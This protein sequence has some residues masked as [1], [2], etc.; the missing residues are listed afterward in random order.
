MTEL[1]LVEGP[2]GT[3]RKSRAALRPVPI[4]KPLRA[5]LLRH[6]LEQGRPSTGLLITGARGGRVSFEALQTRA[7]A[8]WPAGERFTAHELRHTFA[9]WLDAAGVRGT[10]RSML[11]G[12]STGPR[13]G[14]AAVT[15]R[16]THALPGDLELAREQLDAY[17]AREISVPTSVPTRPQQEERPMSYSDL[18]RIVTFRPLNGRIESAGRATSPLR[19]RWGDTVEILARELR[20]IGAQ[21]TVLEVDLAERDFR[22]DGLPRADRRAYTPGIRISFTAGRVPGKPSLRYEVGRFDDW[23]DNVRAVALALEALRKVDRYGVTKRG[24]QY[25]GWAL[26]MG[27]GDPS[28][29]RGRELIR[30][31]GGVKAALK[32]THPDHGGD[33]DAFAD[34]QAAR[35]DGAA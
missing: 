31:H 9:T 29:D 2:P 34:V 16:Y 24:E 15:A 6:L 28:P 33:A 20:A 5:L 26:P 1:L 14:S 23:Q 11:L 13:D 12:H 3:A 25:A 21:R 18:A 4:A 8:A 10:V 27:A 22:L 19:A 7:D 32:A 30:E 35:E 17:I